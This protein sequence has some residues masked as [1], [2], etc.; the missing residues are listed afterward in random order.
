VGM[1]VCHDKKLSTAYGK[2]GEAAFSNTVG[3]TATWDQG[4]SK[5]HAWIS[6]QQKNLEGVVAAQQLMAN[7][8]KAFKDRRGE[9]PDTVIV[10]RDG[11][12]NTQLESFVRDEIIRFQQ[13]FSSLQIRPRLVVI[14]VQ[15]RV[16][17]RMYHECDLYHNRLEYCLTS[18]RCDG[19]KPYHSPVVGTVVDTGVVSNVFNDFFLFSS[20]APPGA[21]AR[22]TRFI[23]VKDEVNF[24]SNDLQR[25]THQMCFIYQNWNGGIRL[26]ATV[27]Y[28]DK[29]A[30]LF[31]KQINGDVHPRLRG[32][33]FFL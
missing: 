1:D 32:S 4:F 24:T 30:Y 14:V 11:V 10:Y 2:R 21:T 15:K 7:A 6:F 12:S 8:C 29:L 9:F 28:A 19:S 18:D 17:A 25:L 31:G 33:L 26:P 27:M 20:I 22:P 13:A 16:T 23:V 5:Y 3:F